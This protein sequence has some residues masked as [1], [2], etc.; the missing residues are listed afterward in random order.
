MALKIRNL[1]NLQHAILRR[2]GRPDQPT[3]DFIASKSPAT[4]MLRMTLRMSAPPISF[5]DDSP[6][7]VSHL[8]APRHKRNRDH[9][10]EFNVIFAVPSRIFATA[11][12]TPS[13]PMNRC[14]RPA[15]HHRHSASECNSGIPAFRSLFIIDLSLILY[16]Q[17]IRWSIL[18]SC[19]LPRTPLQYQSSP[20]QSSPLPRPKLWGVR[21]MN[22][23]PHRCGS[24]YYGR[25]HG[26][27]NKSKLPLY[28]SPY[29]MRAS[30]RE[31][32]TGRKKC[33]GGRRKKPP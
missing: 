13:H 10:G 14:R 23:I 32:G 3:S 9:S 11:S 4:R 30:I 20:P 8:S 18:G 19:R 1:F 12:H 24:K 15:R 5:E 22:E 16:I 31:N 6:S 2:R 21:E 27:S 7:P 33:P 17:N 28:T 25:S 26:V 29:I